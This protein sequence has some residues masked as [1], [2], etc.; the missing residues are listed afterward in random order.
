[1]TTVFVATSVPTSVSSSLFT[2][3][4]SVLEGGYGSYA[5]NTRTT[6][7]SAKAGNQFVDPAESDMDRFILANSVIS[8]VK[9]LVDPFG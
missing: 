5:Q 8:H 2:S 7:A 4:V 3:Q 6:R 9:G 1:M